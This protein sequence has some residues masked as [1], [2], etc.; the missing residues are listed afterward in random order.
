IQKDDGS[1]VG[2]MHACGHDIH[3]T[4]MI[5]TATT[6]AALKDKWSGTV[7]L[8]GQPA[9][10][11]G[12][13]ARMMLDAGLFS[14]FPRPDAC[15]AL[16]DAHDPAAGKVAFTPGWNNANVASVDIRIF[17]KGGHGA[18]PHATVDPI[19]TAAHVILALQTIV[20][21][22]NDPIESAVVTVG[23]IHAGT[24]HNII[25][26]TADLQLTVRTYKDEVRARVLDSIRQISTDMCKAMGCPRPPD[27]KLHD[28]EFTPA[29]YNDPKLTLAAAD[30]FRA[31]LG[32]G[33]VVEKPPTMGGE[34]FGQFPKDAG[35]PGFM[36]G[37]G[38]IA[39][40]RIAEAHKPGATPLP[41]L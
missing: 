22:R 4:V 20:S 15:I 29:C 10:E 34:D 23:S 30:V 28:D 27:I 31:V 6:L 16:H 7:M 9:E 5:G 18:S 24:K 26:D 11:L 8:I 1:Q 36:F 12:K 2:V 35:C 39:P 19:V 17:G 33:N 14:R 25:P 40:S 41:S 21:R 3:Q 13:G 38:T 32:A 37:L